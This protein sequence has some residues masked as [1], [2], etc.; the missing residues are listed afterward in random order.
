MESDLDLKLLADGF[1]FLECPRWHDG[2]LWTS[3]MGAN[4]VWKITPDG[5]REKVAEVPGKPAGLGFLPCGTPIVVSMERRVVY[6][7]EHGRIVVHADLRD[8]SRGMLNDMVVD[9]NGR[10]F[11]DNSGYDAFAGEKWDGSNFGSI[12]LVESD[13]SWREVAGDLAFPNGSLITPGRRLVVAESRI[14]TLTSFAIG[15]DGSLSDRRREADLHGDPD[16]ICLD[17]EGAIWAGLGKTQEFVRVRDG[18]IVQTIPTPGSK[19]V[20]CQLGGDDGC[21]F[22]GL[23]AHGEVSE[24]GRAQLASIGTCGVAVPA[25]NSP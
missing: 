24:I 23:V 4:L 17:A 21:T 22:F 9:T 15:D 10:A 6:R 5:R 16:G 20:A 12:L 11:V 1:G 25:G 7:I 13:G 8:G 2:A 18:Q 19:A 14:R 3:D